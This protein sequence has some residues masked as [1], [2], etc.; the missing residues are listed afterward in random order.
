M[1][2]KSRKR[3]APA[4]RRRSPP[5]A[6]ATLTAA[7]RAKSS[8]ALRQMAAVIRDVF[9]MAC[10]DFSRMLYVSPAYEDVWG[11]PASGILADPMHWFQ[12]VHSADRDR[13]RHVLQQ[14][15]TRSD[16]EVEISFRIEHRLRGTRMLHV[17]CFRVAGAGQADRVV[18]ITR[19]ITEEHRVATALRESEERFELALRGASDGIWDWAIAEDRVWYSNRW[20]SMLGHT[21][22]EIRDDFEEW[23][24]R[25]HPDDLP[26]ALEMI[27]AYFH[28]R[29]PHFILE[30]RLRHKDGSYRWI[31][32]RGHLLRDATGNPHRM[33]GSHVDITEQRE[34][35]RQILE[36]AEAERQR[37]G[38]DLHDDLGQRL[39]ALEM[40]S[41]YLADALQ[42]REPMAAATARDISAQIRQAVAHV[43]RLS[44]GLAPM[45]LQAGDLPDAL[46]DLMQTVRAASGVRCQ[47][48]LR[49]TVVLRNSSEAT[50]LFRIAQE[51][52]NNALKHGHPQ[53]IVVRLEN[54]A[55]ALRL[56]IEDDGVGIDTGSTRGLEHGIS[57][58]RYRARMLGGSLEIRRRRGGGVLV[59]CALQR[60]F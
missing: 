31:L 49:K 35:E 21:P 58:M 52:V 17:R 59:L 43:R 23:R 15:A 32:S 28:N 20:K 51:A 56:A 8:E 47:C 37:I 38:L 26:R 55:G 7:V 13:V 22:D 53:S 11:L 19:D 42:T 48:I 24:A 6:G 2:T 27:D 39:T 25:V 16:S 18:G 12:L 60:K 10:A 45:T 36:V 4:K 41:Q 33:A 54:R 9:W 14:L 44:R 34:L 1:P 30:H 5:R 46:R 40:T 57:L 3:P 50:H 29:V